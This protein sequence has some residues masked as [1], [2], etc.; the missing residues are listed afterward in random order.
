MEFVIVSGL[1]RS[2]TSLMMQM[3]AAGGLEPMRDDLRPADADNPQG[4][5]EWQ[6]IKQLPKNPRLIEKAHGRVTKVISMLLP[7]LPRAH[8]FKV[9]FM[10]RPLEDV[11]ASQERMR[12]RRVSALPAAPRAEMLAELRR[13]RER[14]LELLRATP[15]VEVLEVDYPGLLADPAEWSRRVAAF[16]GLGE[17]RVMAMAGAVAP[18]LCH[19]GAVELAML[20]MP[21]P[22]TG[23]APKP[24]VASRE[25]PWV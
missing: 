19:H 22:G 20:P 18:E 17:D 15:T 5:F 10:M 12:N 9:I 23:C 25:L 1:P 8:R 6:E 7:S 14:M 2:G 16:A 24:R 11:V 4:Y 21:Q 13:H 3:L